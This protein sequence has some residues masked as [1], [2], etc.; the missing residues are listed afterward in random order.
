MPEFGPDNDL[1]RRLAALLEE[2][3]LSEIE[4]EAGGRRIRVGRASGGG[5]GSAVAT[6]SAVPPSAPAPSGPEQHGVEPVPSGALTAPMVG[7][8]YFAPEPGAPPFVQVGD[9]VR[10]GQTLLIIEA[11]KV[12]NPLTAPRAGK[13]SLILVSDGQPVEFGEPLL[14]IE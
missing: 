2:T 3:G 13:V 5:Q 11:M 9:S 10:E 14:V 12:M 8:V 1:I 4:Y 6:P 7:T